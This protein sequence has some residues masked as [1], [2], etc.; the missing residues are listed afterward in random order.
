MEQLLTRPASAPAV[1]PIPFN[2][3]LVQWRE[4]EHPVRREFEDVIARSAF[5]SGPFVDEF[6]REVAAYLGA[7]HAI[8]VNSGTSALHLA[9]LA[10]G[11][12]PGDEVLVPAHTFIASVWGPIYAGATPVLCD[13]DDATGT[14]DVTDAKRRITSRTKAIL[15]VHLY[16]QPAD[17]DA[18]GDLARSHNLTLIED[19]AQAIGARWNGRCVGTHGTLGCFSFYPGKNLGA[20]GEGGLVTTNDAALAQRLRSLRNHGQKERYVHAEI[21]FNYRM[22]GLQSVVLKHKLRRLDAWT[23][24]RR[25]LADLYIDALAGLPIRLP[26]VRNQDHVW[27]LFVI[28]TPEREALRAHMQT[29]SVECGLHYPLPLHRQPCLAHLTGD[30]LSFP[31]ADR[32]ANECLSLPLFYG[33][34]DAQVARV[35][36]KVREFFDGR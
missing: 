2:D 34:T 1:T 28:R 35:A 26:E 32:W 24:R 21:G 18:V 30:R 10:A 8:G 11:V 29:G 25:Q 3:L 14:I 31:N 20:A 4:V 9:M 12:G 36:G 27:H 19:A 17:L 7:G 6:E 15:P 5:T 13:V 16:G 22:D 33:M 23:E